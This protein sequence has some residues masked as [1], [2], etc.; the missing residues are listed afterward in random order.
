MTEPVRSGEQNLTGVW[1]GLYKYENGGSTSFVATLIE[2]GGSL[3]GTT[4]ELSTSGASIATVLFASLIGSRHDSAV[5]F[6]KTY[7]R[8]D[9]LHQRPVVYEGTLNGEEDRDRRPLDDPQKPVRKVL[10]GP[11]ARPNGQGRA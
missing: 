8:P 1:H 9:A 7:D 3:T 11:I 2:S 5:T 6:V 10:D 4:H